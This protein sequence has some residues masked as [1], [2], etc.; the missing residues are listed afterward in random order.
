[1]MVIDG[2]ASP[3][4]LTSLLAKSNGSH[5]IMDG[6][7]SYGSSVPVMFWSKDD[8]EW[9]NYC[10]HEKDLCCLNRMSQDFRNDRLQSIV[11]E[12]NCLTNLPTELVTGSTPNVRMTSSTT[13]HATVPSDTKFLGFLFVNFNPFFILDAYQ[14]F[15]M[16]VDGVVKSNFVI[17]HNP[18]YSVVVPGTL[19]SVCM[20]CNN[21]LPMNSKYIWTPTWYVQYHCDWQCLPDYVKSGNACEY[22]KVELPLFE[23][24]LG[25][26]SSLLVIFIL[27]CLYKFKRS[28][29]H[30]EEIPKNEEERPLLK[31]DMIQFKSEI[32]ELQLRVKKN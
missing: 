16:V 15:R 23:I 7:F 21:P 11:T 5:Y 19:A 3:V 25:F 1:M 17:S 9:S 29:K 31:N 14:G 4:G 13:F 20:H 28:L 32:K 6:R 18:C 12:N 10:F 22:A 26:G 8:H 2:L 27:C 24:G 30:M